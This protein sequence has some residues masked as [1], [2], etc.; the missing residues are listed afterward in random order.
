MKKV[1]PFDATTINSEL[2]TKLAQDVVFAYIYGSLAA[3]RG[4]KESDLDLAIYLPQER[5]EE[6]SYF[7]Y[8]SALCSLVDKE[9]DLVVLNDADIIITM[10]ILTNGALLLCNDAGLLA[11]FKAQ[12]FSE[13]IDFKRSRAV[14]EKAMAKRFQIKKGTHRA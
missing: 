8:Y 3:G 1:N 13:Y 2:I 10:Q 5:A 12:K 4:H 7:S 14:V 6:F 9:L 11:M